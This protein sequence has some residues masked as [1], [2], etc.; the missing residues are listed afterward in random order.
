MVVWKCL[1]LV[2]DQILSFAFFSSGVCHNFF[3]SSLSFLFPFLVVCCFTAFGFLHLTLQYMCEQV[4]AFVATCRYSEVSANK[5]VN[6]KTIFYL[7]FL[8]YYHKSSLLS[9]ETKGFA[10]KNKKEIL[11]WWKLTYSEIWRLTPVTKLDLTAEWK[12]IH[13]VFLALTSLFLYS[14]VTGPVGQRE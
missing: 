9:T 7:H 14:P 4:V 6:L 5:A 8:M 13:S 12:M 10:I 11:N 2:E 3:Q 1:L